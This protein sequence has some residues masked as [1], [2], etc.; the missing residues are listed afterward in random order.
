MLGS[1]PSIVEATNISQSFFGIIL[2]PVMGNAMEHWNTGVAASRG[3][4]DLVIGLAIGN[5]LRIALFI[6]PVLVIL[7]WII[8]QPMSFNFS[9]F[10]A[11]MSFVSVSVVIIIIQDGKSNYLEGVMCVGM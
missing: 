9:D 3:K 8:G 11:I 6:T 10:E 4:M 7:G 5:S 2:I 1:I